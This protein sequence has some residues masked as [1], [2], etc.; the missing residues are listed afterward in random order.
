MPRKFGCT[1]GETESGRRT[2]GAERGWT[3]G[4]AEMGAGGGG[5]GPGPCAGRDEG[6]AESSVPGDTMGDATGLACDRSRRGGS[7]SD[8]CTMLS[9]WRGSW[10]PRLAAGR[11]GGEEP[12][13]CARRSSASASPAGGPP[14]AAEIRSRCWARLVA[15][16]AM[17]SPR[18][19]AASFPMIASSC[20]TEPEDAETDRAALEPAPP[21]RE[22]GK[23]RVAQ[24]RVEVWRACPPSPAL[25]V[26][27]SVA[28]HA[29]ERSPSSAAAS[30]SRA[31]VPRFGDLEQA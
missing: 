11:C 1:C 28:Y 26:H 3:G 7:A 27:R 22:R 15:P 25:P 4:G 12:T 8:R 29:A 5:D 30:C 21:A 24:A 10:R 14:A 20:R 17:A 23:R 2:G 13:C 6:R 18:S 9:M 16:R 31:G 19:S